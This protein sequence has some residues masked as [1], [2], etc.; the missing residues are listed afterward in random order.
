MLHQLIQACTNFV[1]GAFDD[2][3]AFDQ[4]TSDQQAAL[5]TAMLDCAPAEV[6]AGT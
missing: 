3:N 4:L 5:A 6:L 2:D 1:P